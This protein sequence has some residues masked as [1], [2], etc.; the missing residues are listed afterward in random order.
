MSLQGVST[1]KPV[2]LKRNLN[3]SASSNR[4][5]ALL[6]DCRVET[7]CT[8][9]KCPNRNECWSRGTATFLLMGSAC[10]RN[11]GFCAVKT[12]LHS[13]SL[14]DPGE[15]KRVAEAAG[16]MGA[17]YVVLTSVTRDDL[18]DGGSVHFAKTIR[19]L[20]EIPDRKVEVLTPDFLGK[21]QNISRVL[22][23]QP[24]CFAH[25]MET[26]QRL[27]PAVRSQADYAR[28]LNVLAFAKQR[29]PHI[30]TKSSLMMGLGETYAEVIETLKD[31]RKAHCNAVTVGQYLQPAPGNHEV[32][33]YINPEVF[34][35]LAREA[36]KLGFRSAACGPF[37]RSSYHA[38]IFFNDAKEG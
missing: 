27:Y 3:T 25:N 24:D 11:C 5:S 1:G 14:P 35:R 20:K 23:A 10:T 8:Q 9:A 29:A 21:E 31:L 15:P 4:I 18:A 6:S 17:Q 37:V 26:V 32:A 36:R 33:S 12:S 38:E 19:I 30:P 34:D 16:R 2:W 13:L 7:V 28:S 22:E